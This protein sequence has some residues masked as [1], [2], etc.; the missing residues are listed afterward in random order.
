MIIRPIRASAANCLFQASHCFSILQIELLPR[1]FSLHYAVMNTKAPS[2]GVV[3]AIS[4]DLQEFCRGLDHLSGLVLWAIWFLDKMAFQIYQ[5]RATIRRQRSIDSLQI[6]IVTCLT[7]VQ[8][9]SVILISSLLAN[10]QQKL[11]YLQLRNAWQLSSS[12]WQQRGQIES[13]SSVLYV[14]S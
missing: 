8:L 5:I 10:P 13:T 12:S 9:E 1:T 11:A 14:S 3:C 2:T 4:I 7:F 6:G